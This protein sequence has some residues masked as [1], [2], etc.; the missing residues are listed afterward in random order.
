MPQA[1]SEN[2]RS[3]RSETKS[4]S[5]EWTGY[6]KSM[7][8]KLTYFNKNDNMGKTDNIAKVNVKRSNEKRKSSKE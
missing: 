2:K 1:K 5:V 4:S 7:A 3:Y 6:T 8:L